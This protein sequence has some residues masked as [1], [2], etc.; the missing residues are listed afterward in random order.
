MAHGGT[1][2]SDQV[3]LVSWNIKGDGAASERKDAVSTYLSELSPQADILF[4]QEVQWVPKRL[5]RHFTK[6]DSRYELSYYSKEYDNCYNCVIFDSEK[7]E[8]AASAELERDLDLCFRKMDEDHEWMKGDI[9]RT[10]QERMMRNRMAVVIL[11]DKSVEKS[12]FIA[13]SVH[14]LNNKDSSPRMAELFCKLLALLGKRTGYP[15]ILAGDFNAN[16]HKC[17]EISTDNSTI[18]GFTILD[19][20]PTAHRLNHKSPIGDIIDFI[21]FRP[22]TQGGSAVISVTRVWAEMARKDV[23]D[24]KGKI[25]QAKMAK[26]H[27]VSNHDPLRAI[28]K[29]SVIRTSKST[30]TLGISEPSTRVTEKLLPKSEKIRPNPSESTKLPVTKHTSKLPA[31]LQSSNPSSTVRSVN[32]EASSVAH[33]QVTSLPKTVR[34]TKVTQSITQSRKSDRSSA[35]APVVDVPHK[36]TSRQMKTTRRK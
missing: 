6:L 13:A 24:D 22:G 15:V 1:H 31:T 30:K 7:F 14:N 29:I 12:K 17:S 28:M 10:S 3:Q 33:R 34:S 23:I 8:V 35:G 4:L 26:L 16:V 25:N 20:K 9:F 36:A 5:P 19:Y 32:P 18:H 2:H 27:S 21:L 11:C